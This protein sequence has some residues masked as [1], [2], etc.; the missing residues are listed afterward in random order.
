MAGN[1][2]V[3]DT[4]IKSIVDQNFANVKNNVLDLFRLSGS[5]SVMPPIMPHQRP[6]PSS[7]QAANVIAGAWATANRLHDNIEADFLEALTTLQFIYAARIAQPV[8]LLQRIRSKFAKRREG[9]EAVHAL[10]AIRSA[11]MRPEAFTQP[12]VANTT[13]AMLMRD[14]LTHL[15]NAVHVT[16]DCDARSETLREALRFLVWQTG[17]PR[18]FVNFWNHLS[19]EGSRSR[20]DRYQSAN[21][22]FNSIQ[23]LIQTSRLEAET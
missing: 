7:C 5:S 1:R 20:Q 8:Q 10:S 16:A 13:D 4:I 2:S 23:R 6:R 3:G 21:A 15:K 9:E 17:E 19:M 11:M 22:T 12:F 18:L 14:A